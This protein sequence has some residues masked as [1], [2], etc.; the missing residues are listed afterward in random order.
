[1]ETLRFESYGPCQILG[2]SGLQILVPEN[3][4]FDADS[5]NAD[6][7]KRSV[8]AG[9]PFGRV[10]MAVDFKRGVCDCQVEVN[11]V[12]RNRVFLNKFNA[13]FIQS[14][15]NSALNSIFA[16]PMVKTFAR[17]KA[18]FVGRA[19]MATFN[20]AASDASY[21]NALSQMGSATDDRAKFTNALA[22]AGRVNAVSLA[23]F[24]AIH[25]YAAKL[26]G[27][28]TRFGAKEACRFQDFRRF[29]RNR[30]AT[31]KANGF[32]TSARSGLLTHGAAK[33]R[34]GGS[35][36]AAKVNCT[37]LGAD[38]G[39]FQSNLLSKIF[40]SVSSGARLRNVMV[41]G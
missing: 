27:V 38:E 21:W 33:A 16:A 37:A 7:Q 24:F 39:R 20:G 25:F 17:A 23:A 9:V 28:V 34:Y 2:E 11:E 31:A 1:M 41:G 14:L 32:D 26:L 6:L 35:V 12:G 8:S 13:H 4:G 36:R 22:G 5:R 15:S 29:T 10:V 30:F 19:K 40:L 18:R 3:A